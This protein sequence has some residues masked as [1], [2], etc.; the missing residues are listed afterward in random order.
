MKNAEQT[1]NTR[2][3]RRNG[4]NLP[5][6]A[7]TGLRPSTLHSV[8]GSNDVIDAGPVDLEHG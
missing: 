6:F 2:R 7:Q 4:A 5:T 3:P 1:A 8:A